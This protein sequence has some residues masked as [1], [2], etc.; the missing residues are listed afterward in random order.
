MS[1]CYLRFRIILFTVAPICTWTGKYFPVFIISGYLGFLLWTSCLYCKLFFFTSSRDNFFWTILFESYLTMSRGPLPHKNIVGRYVMCCHR[2]TNV[3]HKYQ[4][5]VLRK[6]ACYYGLRVA[7]G[8]QS[9]PSNFHMESSQR[10]LLFIIMGVGISVLYYCGFPISQ[11]RYIEGEMPCDFHIEF[12]VFT[13]VVTWLNQ[14]AICKVI[15]AVGSFSGIVWLI[16][17]SCFPRNVK[18]QHLLGAMDIIYTILKINK[19]R[20]EFISKWS[21]IGK[22]QLCNMY[23]FTNKFNCIF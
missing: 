16:S 4:W 1:I 5:H 11:N 8:P 6:L 10:S 14:H 9:R 3:W 19:K 17:W 22:L 2:P 7:H 15:M 18:D 23:A 13:A 12:T 20:L 21:Y